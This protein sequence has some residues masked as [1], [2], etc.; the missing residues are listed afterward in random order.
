[1]VRI[2]R[3][4]DNGDDMSQLIANE[5]RDTLRRMWNETIIAGVETFTLFYKDKGQLSSTGI[6]EG[7]EMSVT[8][9]SIDRLMDEVPDTASDIILIHTHPSGNATLSAGDIHSHFE[10][11]IWAKAHPTLKQIDGILTLSEEDYPDKDKSLVLYGMIRHTTPRG[12]ELTDLCQDLT[13]MK[14][15]TN[16]AAQGG[17]IDAFKSGIDA[18]FGKVQPYVNFVEI[19]LK[20]DIID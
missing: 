11:I 2:E 16:A 7:S 18:M 5:G 3:P 10:R 20:E 6:S 9:G 4:S 17:K 15:N 13:V 8:S 1:M 19:E 12:K 14:S